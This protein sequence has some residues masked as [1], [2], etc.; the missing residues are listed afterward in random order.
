[1]LNNGRLIFSLNNEITF[2]APKSSKTKLTGASRQ[3]DWLISK[4]T[5]NMQVINRWVAGGGGGETGY[6]YVLNDD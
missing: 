1:M 6:K 4:S 3:M 5:H 2:I